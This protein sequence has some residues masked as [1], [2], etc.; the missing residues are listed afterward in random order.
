MIT[1][2]GYCASWLQTPSTPCPLNCLSNQSDPPTLN[3]ETTTTVL[4]KI[5]VEIHK[6]EVKVQN[7]LC[8]KSI[9]TVL[10]QDLSNF[11]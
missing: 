8:V 2:L 7:L 3:F 9:K 1:W 4:F 11:P 6:V 10:N 5:N